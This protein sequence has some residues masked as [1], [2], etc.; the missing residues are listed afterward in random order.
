MIVTASVLIGGLI[1]GLNAGLMSCQAGDGKPNRPLREAELN[2]LA[3]MRM[4]NATDARAGLAGS[5]GP[6]GRQTKVNGWVDW[7]RSLV[8]LAVANQGSTALVQARPGMLAVRPNSPATA[9]PPPKEPPADGWRVRP[10]NLAEKEAT[11]L[12]NLVAFLF[13]IAHD[14][15]DNTDLL[16]K[17]STK[18]VRKDRAQGTDVDVLLGPAVFPEKE[19][20]TASASPGPSPSDPGSLDAQGGAV[21]YWLDQGGRL[22]KVETLLGTNMPTN[23]EFLRDD[24]ADFVAV[25]ALGG[26]DNSPREVN[27]AEAELLSLMRQRNFQV[28]QASVKLTLPAMPGTLRTAQGWLDWQRSIF[29]LSLHDHDDSTKDSLVHATAKGVSLRKLDG[30]APE[31]PPVPTMKEWETT[32]WSQLSGS[33]DITDLDVILFEALSLALNQRDDAQRMRDTARL[34]RMDMLGSDPVGVF[35]LP[36]SVEH[37]WAPGTSRLRYWVDNAGVL[38]RLEARTRTGGLAQLDITPTDK[39]PAIPSSVA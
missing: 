38:R 19:K 37:Q 6:P 14:K 23:I 4:H 20:E 9:G 7:K 36:N 27:E 31:T 34:L 5:V 22:R 35:E 24:R 33:A 39:I 30:N 11:A 10:L 2:R 3:G 29:Y 1:V 8:Y 16:R 26:R 28:R 32:T 13:V 25:D 17:L 12:D 18:W 21:G 15:P